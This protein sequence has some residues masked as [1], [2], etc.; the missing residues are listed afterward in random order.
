MKDQA[1]VCCSI[2]SLTKFDTTTDSTGARTDSTGTGSDGTGTGTDIAGTNTEE[3]LEGGEE[4]E[5]V[6]VGGGY[7]ASLLLHTVRWA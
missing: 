6:T 3:D 1:K 5:E 4:E 7:E 2:A